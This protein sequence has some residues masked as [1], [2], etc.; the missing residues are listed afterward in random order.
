MKMASSSHS[1]TKSEISIWLADQ[2][3]AHPSDDIETIKARVL[4]QLRNA[5][6]EM[7]GTDNLPISPSEFHEITSRVHGDVE[8]LRQ[9]LRISPEED[10]VSINA[11]VS[12]LAYGA[13]RQAIKSGMIVYRPMPAQAKPPQTAMAILAFCSNPDRRDELLGDAEHRF[14]LDLDR[15]GPRFARL[16]LYRLIIGRVLARGGALIEWVAGIVSKANTPK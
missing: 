13:L 4:K 10:Q 2:I 1:W 8:S 14:Q 9:Q 15:F 5:E 7:V 11:V 6:I 12:D 16:Y 3:A